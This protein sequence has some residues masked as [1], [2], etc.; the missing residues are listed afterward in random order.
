M[1]SDV[2]IIIGIMLGLGIGFG[3]AYLLLKMQQKGQKIVISRNKEGQIDSIIE[4]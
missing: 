1:N 4:A 3:M 2:A